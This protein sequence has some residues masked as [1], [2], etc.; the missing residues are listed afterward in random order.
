MPERRLGSHKVL[1]TV[2]HPAVILA[3][4]HLARVGREIRPGD[5]VVDADLGAA[6]AGEER[7]GLISAGF[8]VAVGLLVVDALRQ[9]AGV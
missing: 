5:V 8:A 2:R 1:L 4:R 7:L 6:Q 9:E 3:L